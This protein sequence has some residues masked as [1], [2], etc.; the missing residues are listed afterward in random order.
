[1][2]LST[3]ETERV[4]VDLEWLAAAAVGALAESLG[5]VELRL[6]E[7]LV[8]SDRAWV[9][10]AVARDHAGR[11]H[12][13]VLK[14]PT[15][16]DQGSLREEAALG[17]ATEQRLPGVVRLLGTS[18]A[19]PLLVLADLGA[20]PTLADRLLGDDPSSAE[21]AVLAWAGAVGRLQAESTGLR[22][23]FDA[24][25]AALSPLGPPVVDT[26]AGS[27]SEAAGVL[28]RTL[29]QLGVAIRAAAIDELHGV[30]D[31]LDV[32]AP[33]SPGGLVPGDTCPSNAIE[34]ENGMV[35]LDF[36]GAEYRHLA[37]EAAY[38][39]VPWPSCWCSWGL[40]AQ[41]SAN[42]LDRWRQ[43]VMTTTPVVA[44]TRF[45][46]DLAR[47]TIGWVFISA[48]WFL[49]G[50]LDGDP[51]PADPARR[52]MVPTRRALLQ[53]RLGVAAAYDT[54][55]LPEL[56]QLA[57]QMYE[58]TTRVWGEHPLPLAPAFR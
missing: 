9:V 40:P 30:A 32:S 20:G 52:S 45:A 31:A 4:S 1:M 53:H 7:P 41:V 2:T 55:V 36:E 23:E 24:R 54:T 12:R 28:T 46:D 21:S 8:S 58:A 10:R 6:G 44:T 14:A 56:R 5:P 35:L 15:G 43:A 34:T 13:V 22:P 57:A 37:W 11:G 27:V 16:A 25:L 38:L 42:A 17:L 33:G 26:S 47:A 49:A 50:A 19:P 3:K 39:S 18:L 48:G 29:P 51:P